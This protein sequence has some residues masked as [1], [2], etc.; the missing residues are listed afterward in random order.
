MFIK[1]KL[2]SQKLS[3]RQVVLFGYARSGSSYLGQFVG[4]QEQVFYSYEPLDALY[5]SLYGT[6][7]GWNCH[8]D[9]VYFV[10][11]SER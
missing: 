7:E 8:S 1:F 11:G 10:N 6:R 2:F 9:I 5:V 4:G 3:P